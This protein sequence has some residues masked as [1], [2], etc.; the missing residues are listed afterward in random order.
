M[1]FPMSNY[2]EIIVID[3]GLAIPETEAF[4]RMSKASKLPLTYHLPNFTGCGS[5]LRTPLESI[6]GVIIFGSLASV[7]DQ[8][9]WLDELKTWLHTEIISRR[10][11]IFGIC[12]GH[13]LL[14]LM[15]GG[16]V[17]FVHDSKEL[18][19]GKRRITLENDPRLPV[20]PAQGEVFI[21]HSEH[22][23]ELGVGFTTWAKGDLIPL[24]ASYHQTL[25]IWTIQAHPEG[26]A[27]DCKEFNVDPSSFSN[28]FGWNIVD[29]FLDFCY[30]RP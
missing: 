20:N 7:H 15:C 21:Y 10:I 30:S 23:S 5:L 29:T 22:V 25:P 8:R 16:K 14:H 28:L 18:E 24:E 2:R 27:A 1:S 13:Q 4:N 26:T 9:P 11:P 3:P 19:I 12:F 17:E 6:G